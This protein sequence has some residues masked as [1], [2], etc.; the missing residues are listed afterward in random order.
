[1]TPSAEDLHRMIKDLDKRLATLEQVLL[2]A[3]GSSSGAGGLSPDATTLLGLPDA[4][5][6]TLMSMQ[7]LG[8]ADAETVSKSTGRTRSV[9]NIYLN[10][11]ARLGHLGKVRKGKKV[12]FRLMKYY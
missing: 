6:K 3:P 8:E 11:L 7:S 9:E 4:L 12:F 2:R 10:Q 1:M 5:R